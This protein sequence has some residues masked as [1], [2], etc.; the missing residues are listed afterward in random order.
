MY[1]IICLF[2]LRLESI[3]TPKNLVDV[4]SVIDI[5]SM[6]KFNLILGELIFLKCIIGYLAF[7]ALSGDL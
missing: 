1:N 5:L 4:F 6:N 3:V 7:F 2:Q